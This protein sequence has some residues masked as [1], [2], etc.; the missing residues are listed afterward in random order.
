MKNF[1]TALLVSTYNWP[2]ALALV[3]KSVEKQTKKPDEFIIADDGSRSETTALIED[4]KKTSGLNV[5]HVWHKDDGFKRSEILNKAIAQSTCDYIV[6]TDGDCIIHPK[7]IED[8]VA[9]AAK[10]QYL[11]GSRVS[12]IEAYRDELFE[13]KNIKFNFLHKGIKKRTRALY[14]PFLSSLYGVK[15]EL[16]KKLRGCNVSFWREDF[17]AV[18]GYNEAMTG[19]GREDSELIIRMMNKGVQ[20]RRLRYRGIVY[21]IWHKTASKDSVNVNEAIQ[22]KAINERLDW[23]EN[24][25]D[26]YLKN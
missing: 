14:L 20:A 5:I 25:V 23:C 13:T 22:Q 7:F 10:N 24:G 16:S 9:F 15:N 3:F 8:H 12:I 17:I 21:H 2:E 11:Y 6:Q 18:N 26:K 1:K 19:W 4:F